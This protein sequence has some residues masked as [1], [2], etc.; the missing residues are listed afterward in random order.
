[1]RVLGKLTPLCRPRPLDASTWTAAISATPCPTRSKPRCA[2][3]PD[4]VTAGTRLV[5][6]PPD[7]RPRS[8]AGHARG[9]RRAAGGDLAGHPRP[10]RTSYSYKRRLC[11]LPAH[12]LRDRTSGG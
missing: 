1:M 7:L 4:R 12:D 8:H 6:P 11:K 5:A 3:R 10:R 2:G 9:G